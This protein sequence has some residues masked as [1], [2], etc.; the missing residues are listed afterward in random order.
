M[1][2]TCHRWERPEEFNHLVLVFLSKWCVSKMFQDMGE[3]IGGSHHLLL[4]TNRE[5]PLPEPLD[6]Q[7][8]NARDVLEV[9][10]RLER[11]ILRAVFDYRRSP[12]LPDAGQCR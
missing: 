11:S 2:V 4:L 1:L 6:C 7:L 10:N 12:F 3:N 5:A 8:A 9:V